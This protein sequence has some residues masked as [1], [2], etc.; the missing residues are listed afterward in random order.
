MEPTAGPTNIERLR[1]HPH[2]DGTRIEQ[3]LSLALP[4]RDEAPERL[5]R[6][7]RDA[8]FPGGHRIRPRL[9]LAVARTVPAEAVDTEL[10]LRAAC[11][12]ELVHCASLVH[13]DLPCFDDAA[14]RRGQASIHA[15]H[16]ETTAVLTGDALFAVAFELV[17]A[18]CD[19]PGRALRISRRLSVALGSRFGLIG[20]QSLE[21][22]V[23]N[24]TPLQL[25]RYHDLKTAPLFRLAAELGAL[26][27]GATNVDDW[28]AIGHAIGAA[29]QLADDLYDRRDAAVAGKPTGRDAALG[30]PNAAHVLGETATYEQLLAQLAHARTQARA[31]TP[32]PEPILTI[33]DEVEH[34]F[35][36]KAA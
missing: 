1:S 2:D 35:E 24:P 26:A 7:M 14:M 10:V 36:G 29:F 16:G 17:T 13:D 32:V 8:V 31:C 34:A 27:S 5:H 21:D 25:Q 6:A 22:E 11:A 15:A 20:G 33:I 12:I 4:P 18:P 23:A 28:G 30:R 19:H 9:A 3:A